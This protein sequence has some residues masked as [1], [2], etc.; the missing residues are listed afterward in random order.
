MKNFLV[1]AK[2]VDIRVIS[3]DV[4]YYTDVVLPVGVLQNTVAVDIDRKEGD[5]W[6][7]F[8]EMQAECVLFTIPIGSDQLIC[9]CFGLVKQYDYTTGYYFWWHLQ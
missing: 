5:Y 6:N 4:D 8:Q 2:K 3:L 7:Y 9:N 1:F